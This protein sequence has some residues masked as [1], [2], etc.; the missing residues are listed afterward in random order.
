MLTRF[1][2]KRAY[3]LHRQR[4]ISLA[5]CARLQPSSIPLVANEGEDADDEDLKNSEKK[6]NSEVSAS[7]TSDIFDKLVKEGQQKRITQQNAHLIPVVWNS[8]VSDSHSNTESCDSGI[9][10]KSLYDKPAASARCNLSP[11][12]P[13]ANGKYIKECQSKGTKGNF[14]K[15]TQRNK[16]LVEKG[17]TKNKRGRVTR[18][19]R[20]NTTGKIETELS[21]EKLRKISID[22]SEIDAYSFVVEKI[23]RKTTCHQQPNFPSRSTLNDDYQ[24]NSE[25]V[26]LVTNGSKNISKEIVDNLHNDQ[27]S[28]SI[29]VEN[30]N[31]NLSSEPIAT[32]LSDILSLGN[33]QRQQRLASDKEKEL[34]RLDYIEHSSEVEKNYDSQMSQHNFHAN[35]C[36]LENLSNISQCSSPEVGWFATERNS[37]SQKTSTPNTRVKYPWEKRLLKPSKL[38]QR[39]TELSENFNGALHNNSESD[40]HETQNDLK[41]IRYTMDNLSH[42]TRS[43]VFNMRPHHPNK[44]GS[45]FKREKQ[46]DYVQQ[47]NDIS[48]SQISEQ[49]FQSCEKSNN[50]SR[51]QIPSAINV[52]AKQYIEE[53]PENKIKSISAD[54]FLEVS[55]AFDPPVSSF[56]EFSPK[57]V[58][59]VHLKLQAEEL[60]SS[61][62]VVLTP[63]QASYGRISEITPV[64]KVLALCDQNEPIPFSEAF[65]QRFLSKCKKIG[66]GVYGEVFHSN[67]PQGEEIAIKIIPIEGDFP[68]NEESQKNFEEIL[69]EIVVSKEL[70]KLNDG[71]ENMTSTFILVK[72]VMCVQGKYPVKLLQEWDKF[73][74][75]KTTLNDR[76]DIFDKNQ[77]YI[78]FEFSDGGCDLESFHFT[79]GE[80]AMSVLKQVACALAVAEEALQYEHRDLHWGNIL[81]ARSKKENVEFT[82]KGKNLTFPACGVFVSI[83]DFTLSR[84]TKDGCTVFTDLTN[85]QTL[86]TGEG[87][88][89]F[90]I[91]RLMKKHNKN[92]WESFHP[93]TNILWLHYLTEKLVNS[94]K[95]ES[96]SKNHRV[97]IGQLRSLMSMLLKFQSASD[98]IQE[99]Y[100][101]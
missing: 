81:V 83:I 45:F 27:E 100:T 14:S 77:L 96:R 82:F 24:D 16:N 87:D 78:V 85:D 86:F 69:P 54:L 89:Q 93:F 41:V 28:V 99:Y 57:A 9:L 25:F 31:V 38:L 26:E 59:D 94:K 62:R 56:Y 39:Q 20:S 71:K 97:A 88:Y 60:C 40:L 63:L 50:D 46:K 29:E 47:S 76:P 65:P 42:T 5:P 12:V 4:R 68:V 19:N 51:Q 8:S 7:E 73:A 10:F 72:R 95:Y 66:E 67:Y 48:F 15:L 74:K 17:K 61:L 92:E 58:K 55:S 34:S 53:N 22:W 18:H 11:A 32:T 23:P 44:I 37:S 70:S 3:G 80:E 1:Q 91:Y 33:Q 52:T 6:L 13:V 35:P 49:L 84:F 101:S 43:S 2:N 79:S 36:L 75:N 30:Q 21:T 64:H 98:F 90:E